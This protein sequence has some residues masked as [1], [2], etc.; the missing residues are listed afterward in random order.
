[1]SLSIVILVLA[2]L[3]MLL[4][5][6]SLRGLGKHEEEEVLKRELFRARVIYQRDS[7]ASS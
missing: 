7:P 5:V 6:R 2:F 3:S 4:A 1:M